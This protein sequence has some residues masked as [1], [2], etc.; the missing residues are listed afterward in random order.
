MQDYRDML[1]HTL[2]L[3]AAI[4]LITMPAPDARDISQMTAGFIALES[5]LSVLADDA[6]ARDD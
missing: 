5:Q 4:F 2:L 3:A 6:V 1:K